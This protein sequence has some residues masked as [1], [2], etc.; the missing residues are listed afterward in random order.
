MTDGIEWLKDAQQARERALKERKT[1]LIDVM[2]DHCRGCDKLDAVTYP[3][4][5]V[6]A[7]VTSRFV[8]L[9][10]NLF[11]SPRD[12]IRPLD[13]IWTPTI[14]FTDRRGTVHYRSINFLPPSLFLTL[15]D[16][17]EANVDLRWSRTDHAIELLRDAYQRDPE[18]ALAPEVLYHLGIATYLKSHSNTDLYGVWDVLR[19][20]FPDSIWTA[21]I[22]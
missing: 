14:L 15:L 16:I 6:A 10:L 17:G 4:P 1:I 18:G 20:R 8:P 11:R 7:A 3:D 9:K 12:V 21:R 5:E 13:V 2:K 19:E 22:P